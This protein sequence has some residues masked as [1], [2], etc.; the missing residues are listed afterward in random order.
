MSGTNTTWAVVPG[1]TQDPDNP[2]QLPTD[3]DK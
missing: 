1:T 3:G 2:T